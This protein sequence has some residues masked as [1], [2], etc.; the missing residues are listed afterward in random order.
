MATYL[1]ILYVGSGAVQTGTT[2]TV[3]IPAGYIAGDTLLLFVSITS[4]VSVPSGWSLLS[5]TT[6]TPSGG[7]VYSKIATSSESS[8]SL[9]GLNT[10]TSSVIVAYRNANGFDVTISSGGGTSTSATTLANAFSP[11]FNGELRSEEHTSEL[12]SH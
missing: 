2:Q 5:S 10:T 7:Y 12:Q 1:P 3:P 9:S 11:S 8:V 4:S 6:N